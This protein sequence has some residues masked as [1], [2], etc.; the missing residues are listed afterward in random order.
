MDPFFEGR[1]HIM[2]GSALSDQDWAIRLAVYHQFAENARPPTY[3]EIGQQL[4]L[5]VEEVRRAYQRLHQHHALFLDSGAD[6]IRMANPLSAVPTSYRV[7]IAGRRL[8]A[9]CAWDSLGIPAMLHVDARIETVFA[10]SGRPVSYAIQGGELIGEVA[11][12]VHF[13]LPFRRWYDD[14][15]HT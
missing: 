5:P 10:D 14:P 13:P 2:V 7:E 12:V 8:W 15:I 4:N 11:C 3:V 9:N 1:L 6:T